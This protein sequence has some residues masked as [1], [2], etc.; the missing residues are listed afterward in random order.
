MKVENYL[1]KFFDVE[2]EVVELE[3]NKTA[4]RIEIYEKGEDCEPI[5]IFMLPE[6]STIYTYRNV[7]GKVHSGTEY[8]E[9]SLK[10]AAKSGEFI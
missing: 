6:G 2:V 5:G 10:R 3:E 1:K 8:T 7:Y 9:D 4:T